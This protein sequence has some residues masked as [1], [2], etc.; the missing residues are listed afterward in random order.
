MIACKEAGKLEILKPDLFETI[1][2]TGS[3]NE[4]KK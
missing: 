3:Y 2:R 1:S 4:K